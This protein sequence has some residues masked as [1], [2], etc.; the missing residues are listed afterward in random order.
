MEGRTS[1]VIAQRISTVLNADQILVLTKVNSSHAVHEELLENSP[2][3]AEIYYRSWLKMSRPMRQLAHKG[4]T[5][6]NNSA[7][8]FG[9]ETLKASN[10]RSTLRRFGLLS[11]V[12]ADIAHGAG[13]SG[14]QHVHDRARAGFDRPVC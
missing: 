7:Q 14:W 10:V 11:P 3:Y 4:C 8:P 5:A 6:F 13:L 9:Q 1:F 12:L 2:I